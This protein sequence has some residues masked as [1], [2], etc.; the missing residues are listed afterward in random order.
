[1][2]I[3]RQ[4]GKKAGVGGRLLRDDTEGNAKQRRAWGAKCP[5]SPGH[6]PG[7]RFAGGEVGQLG[8]AGGCQRGTGS[9]AETQQ[10]QS[11]QIKK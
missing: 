11:G 5:P 9:G 4:W 1:M 3:P 8:R 2:V 6:S 7:K 10:S